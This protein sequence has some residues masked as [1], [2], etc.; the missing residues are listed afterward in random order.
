MSLNEEM[1][2]IENFPKF[3]QPWVY[4]PN[5]NYVP[6]PPS[7][8]TAPPFV[9]WVLLVFIVLILSFLIVLAVEKHTGYF[10]KRVKR[11]RQR[12]Q[13]LLNEIKNNEEKLNDY[14]REKANRQRTT[15]KIQTSVGCVMLL[16]IIFTFILI[17][18][19]VF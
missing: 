7:Y 19:Y 11:K 15:D 12:E 17:F 18:T 9:A 10:E 13:E 6:P 14:Y 2:M 3:V 16:F 4:K 1:N 8:E 5:P